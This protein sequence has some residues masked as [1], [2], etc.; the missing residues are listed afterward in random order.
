MLRRIRSAFIE[1]QPASANRLNEYKILRKLGQGTF[2]TVSLCVYLPTGENFAMK[3]LMKKPLERNMALNRMVH[4]EL[5]ILTGLDHP[6]VIKLKEWFETK[7][8]YFLIFEYA[9]G[10]ELFQRISEKGKFT[11]MDAAKIAYS[12]LDALNYIHEH[13]IVHRDLKPENVLYRDKTDDSPIVIADFGVSN[14]VDDQTMLQTMVGSPGYAAPEVIERTGHNKPAD[15]WSVGII[16]YTLLCGFHPF[17]ACEDQSQLLKAVCK[18]EFKFESPYWDNV[19]QEAQ[20]F[21]ISLLQ[22]DPS[23]RPKAK[24]A[25]LHSW[26]LAHVSAARVRA[27]TLRPS[28]LTRKLDSAI[29]MASST[30]SSSQQSP[31]SP[32][33]SIDDLHISSSSEALLDRSEGDQ[34]STDSDLPDLSTKWEQSEDGSKMDLN[35]ARRALRR[36]LT[37]ASLIGK[38]QLQRKKSMESLKGSSFAVENDAMPT[39]NP[40]SPTSPPRIMGSTGRRDSAPDLKRI[41]KPSIPIS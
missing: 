40:L 30:Q 17:H 11:E 14:I 24:Q 37:A 25:M 20:E 15:I 9:S 28:I 33:G 10:G 8:K 23:K 5:E 6:N 21:V 27:R 19:S 12:L 39:A 1:P 31:T 26:L 36:V 13:N 34:R 41:R 32:T 29:D 2:G 22:L 7:D 18:A 38:M 16:T 4:R 3:T 35:H